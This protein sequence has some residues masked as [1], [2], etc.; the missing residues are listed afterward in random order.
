M[1][2]PDPDKATQDIHDLQRFLDAQASSYETALS[3]VRNGRKRSHWMWYIFP[4]LRELGR[5]STAQHYG[6][7]GVDEA[8][9]YLEHP[10]LGP[11]LTSICKAALALEGHSATEIF[12][13]PDDLKLRSCATLFAQI[14]SA[15]PV[16]QHLLDKY[17][18]GQ[19]D[20]QTLKILG[21]S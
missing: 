4:Q 19:P 10:V 8:R 3:E 5:S 17:Y 16:F 13:R 12:G 7:A 2:T 6:I 1:H 21:K 9:A 15:D 11:R 18:D 20:T 14:P